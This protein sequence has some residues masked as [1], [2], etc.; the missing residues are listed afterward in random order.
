MKVLGRELAPPFD[1]FW[2]QFKREV[3]VPAEYVEE[4]HSSV[5]GAHGMDLT[6]PHMP[7]WTSLPD[8][9]LA[10]HVAHELTHVVL[11][12]RGFPRTG[13]GRGYPDGS[14]E[15]K[16]GGDLEEMVLHPV[17]E[18][19]LSPFGFKK[20][21]IQER[22]LRGAL[23][24]LDRSPVP[25]RGT[26]WSFTWAI[27]YCELQLELPRVS[28]RRLEAAYR[29]RS[30]EVCDLGEELVVIM[31]DVGWGTRDQA[32]EAMIRVRDALGLGVDD[33]VLVF[34]PVSGETL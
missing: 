20:D 28:W 30:V 19:L 21:F 29:S 24:G 4:G 31:R 5:F 14:A 1:A 11:R 22:M 34:D 13:R 33:R 7:D 3:P 6:A 26:P 18:T 23:D 12:E 32:L 8:D 17:L 9:D 25:D 27:R 16:V 10:Y 15:E 2:E